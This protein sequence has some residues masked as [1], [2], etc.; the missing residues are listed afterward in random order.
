MIL[1]N[2]KNHIGKIIK[3]SLI[4]VTHILISSVFAKEAFYSFNQ[5]PNVKSKKELQ[6]LW[7]KYV[8][9]TDNDVISLKKDLQID[10]KHLLGFQVDLDN[11][12]ILDWVL[13]S[14]HGYFC[15]V[16]NNC[17]TYFF[18]SLLKGKSVEMCFSPNINENIQVPTDLTNQLKNLIIENGQRTMKFDGKSYYCDM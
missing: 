14:K 13:S 9:A 1:L 16:K 7:I 5:V 4:V 15:G 2:I 8:K 12:G 10:E 18:P 11:D 6:M 3:V 17:T